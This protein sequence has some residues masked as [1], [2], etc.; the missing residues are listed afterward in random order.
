[1][2]TVQGSRATSPQMLRFKNRDISM[3]LSPKSCHPG[4][5]GRHSGNENNGGLEDSCL[6]IVKA[7]QPWGRNQLGCRRKAPAG[8]L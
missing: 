1:M 4:T 3:Y 2:R 6:A 5:G 7:T 8:S